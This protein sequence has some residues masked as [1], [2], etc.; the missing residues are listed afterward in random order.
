MAVADQLAADLAPEAL[1]DGG[2]I[3]E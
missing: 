2:G 1:L 3:A